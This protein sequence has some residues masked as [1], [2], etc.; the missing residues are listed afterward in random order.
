MKL[1]RLFDFYIATATLIGIIWWLA[2]QQLPVTM[3]KISLITLAGLV[4]Y[5][6]DRSLFP[7]ARPDAF[8]ASH[9]NDTRFSAA[10]I[11]RAVIVGST[12]LG[13]SLGV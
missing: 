1:P 2:P 6:L 9:V 10:M 8:V 11:R 5:W 13:V 7:Y 4:G 12:I 3:Y